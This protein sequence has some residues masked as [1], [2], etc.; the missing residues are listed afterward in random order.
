M[1]RPSNRRIARHE[2][3]APLRAFASSRLRVRPRLPRS[4]FRAGCAPRGVSLMEVLIAMFVLSMGLLGVAAVIPLAGHEM[5]QAF[6]AD[7]SSACAQAALRDA[8]VRGMLNPHK[9]EG[10]DATGAWKAIGLSQ[11]NFGNEPYH[12]GER[13]FEFGESYA[14]DSLYM[15]ECYGNTVPWQHYADF[16]YNPSLPGSSFYGR[17]SRLKRVTFSEIGRSNPLLA[18]AV[19]MWH[20][21]KLFPLPDDETQRPEQLVRAVRHPGPPEHVQPLQSEFKGDYSW[22]MTVTPSAEH[23]DFVVAPTAYSFSRNSS[24]YTVSVAVFYKR[25]MTEPNGFDTDGDGRPDET[26]AERQ[27]WVQFLGGGLGGGDVRLHVQGDP[28][29]ANTWAPAHYLDVK[30]NEWLLVSGGYTAVRRY[31]KPAQRFCQVPVG[32]HKWYR[33]VAVGETMVGQDYDGDGTPDPPW[34]EVTL[35]GPDWNADNWCFIVGG[36]AR[37]C[38]ALFNGVVAV[39]STDVKLDW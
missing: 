4:S 3:V 11:P 32:V 29:D 37:A 5:L 16:P 12:S 34:R 27:V 8:R 22:L 21:D 23:V 10:Y 2:P 35:A 14:I 30:E 25:D 20:D 6:K 9:W 18:R 15:T 33:I 31:E 7:R 36:K 24:L 38:A 28:A 39:H 13:G 26:P 17:W 1:K 19:F